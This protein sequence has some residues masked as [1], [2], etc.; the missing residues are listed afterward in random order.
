MY[1]KVISVLKDCEQNNPHHDKAVLMH[2]LNIVALL[3][4]YGAD[5][6]LIKAG[7]LHD[8]GKPL[9]K[10][11]VNGTDIFHDHSNAGVE[12]IKANFDVN[13]NVL[14][15]VKYHDTTFDKSKTIF[16]YI[17]KF[18]IKFMQDLFLLRYCDI[19]SQSKHHRY[20]KLNQFVKSMKMFVD[21]IKKVA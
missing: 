4:D 9:V 18:G 17:R 1:D 21:C 10:Q 6:D 19:L 15:L 7:Y 5:A 3:S 11:C 20:E 12:Y 2:T 16:R 14:N 13:D 8:I